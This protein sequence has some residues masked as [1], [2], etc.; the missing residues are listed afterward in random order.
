VI[1]AAL[2]RGFHARWDSLERGILFAALSRASALVSWEEEMNKVLV[3]LG[4]C[5]LLLSVGCLGQYKAAVRNYAESNMTTAMTLQTL[6]EGV[7]CEQSDAA[8]A[9]ECSDAVDRIKK[10]AQTLEKDSQELKAKAQ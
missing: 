6:I 7:K 3:R 2:A 5:G 8:K 10:V 9:K 4:L 1:R